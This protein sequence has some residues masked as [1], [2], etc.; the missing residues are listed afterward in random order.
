M[1]PG[2]RKR[3]RFIQP[4]KPYGRLKI[5]FTLNYH[6][7]IKFTY[8]FINLLNKKI[9]RN[10]FLMM[11]KKNK[12]LLQNMTI[13]SMHI[14]QA[15]KKTTFSK[16]L[17]LDRIIFT[18]RF[19]LRLIRIKVRQISQ[20]RYKQRLKKKIKIQLIQKNNG[21]RPFWMNRLKMKQ[22]MIKLK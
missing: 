19:G 11:K 20:F 22:F 1:M 4:Y 12:T 9:R 15:F 5:C 6:L 21:L 17:S 10:L 14:C 3:Y 18:I 2:W 7:L 13:L 16:K 8:K